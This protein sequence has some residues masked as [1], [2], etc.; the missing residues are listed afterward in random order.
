MSELPPSLPTD[1]MTQSPVQ[2]I[3]I[4]SIKGSSFMIDGSHEAFPA[5]DI[6]INLDSNI[7]GPDVLVVGKIL[8]TPRTDVEEPNGL[9]LAVVRVDELNGSKSF[10]IVTDK[11][12]EDGTIKKKWVPLSLGVKLTVGRGDDSSSGDPT[13]IDGKELTGKDYSL[14]VSR[15]HMSVE[16]TSNG[17]QVEDL[18][19]TNGTRVEAI[20]AQPNTDK[21][22]STVV[23]SLVEVDSV[24]GRRL[25]DSDSVPKSAQEASEMLED[26]EI[27]KLEDKYKPTLDTLSEE[28]NRLT[29]GLSVDDRLELRAFQNG[30]LLIR[31]GW[32]VGEGGIDYTSVG[33][34]NKRDAYD[35]MSNKAQAV[36][37][38]WSQKY[39][40][41]E[42][43]QKLMRG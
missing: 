39:S 8:D 29:E 13:F 3:A 35:K 6:G 11:I 7:Q 4:E 42:E 25:I 20:K 17:I 21:I 2:S 28:L 1:A 37:A 9:D 34:Q 38:Q 19:S 18:N 41:F 24:P 23:S 27:S 5:S 16:L 40:R 32:E 22:S 14:G 30:D 43:I 10:F 26:S 33:E 31:K 36:A 15:R 12:Q